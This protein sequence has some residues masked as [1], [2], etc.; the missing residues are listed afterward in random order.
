MI[1][2]AAIFGTSA[3]SNPAAPSDTQ[4]GDSA[5]KVAAAGKVS[6]AEKPKHISSSGLSPRRI[7][8][9]VGLSDGL[10]PLLVGAFVLVFGFALVLGGT[11]RRMATR[12]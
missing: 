7:A 5:P 11:T 1:D 4:G 6:G 3:I 12:R 10:Q 8:M 2:Q 9:A